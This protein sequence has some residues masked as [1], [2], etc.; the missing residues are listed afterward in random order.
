MLHPIPASSHHERSVSFPAARKLFSDQPGSYCT[1]PQKASLCES[2]FADSCCR[3]GI[4]SL[5]TGTRFGVGWEPTSLLQ[6]NPSNWQFT[7]MP[8]IPCS[9]NDTWIWEHP[10]KHVGHVPVGTGPLLWGCNFTNV[11]QKRGH[12]A[13]DSTLHGGGT[14]DF[15]SKSKT[16]VICYKTYFCYLIANATG[17]GMFNRSQFF[18]SYN[19]HS[20]KPHH[21]HK[22]HTQN[23]GKRCMRAILDLSPMINHYQS[24]TD[25]GVTWYSKANHLCAWGYLALTLISAVSFWIW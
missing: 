24:D 5:D 2:H 1:R 4:I 13:A 23:Q 20:K 14:D 8:G 17:Y 3:C 22:C 10:T 21:I 15:R 7:R 12:W 25:C 9:R 6:D 11:V 16:Q 19:K 18:N